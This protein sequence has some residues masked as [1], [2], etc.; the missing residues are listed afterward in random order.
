ME[1]E[2]Y[3][4]CK[5]VNEQATLDVLCYVG[6]A[7]GIVSCS[8]FLLQHYTTALD[9][10]LELSSNGIFILGET[11]PATFDVSVRLRVS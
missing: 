11:S 3:S 7:G 5:T 8:F 10:L 6:M 9:L 2:L 1:I 4:G